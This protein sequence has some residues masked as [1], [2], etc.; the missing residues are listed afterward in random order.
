M[1]LRIKTTSERLRTNHIDL[2]E[3]TEK[4]SQENEKL[5]SNM[6]KLLR[7]SSLPCANNT[8]V[9]DDEPK[10]DPEKT[11]MLSEMDGLRAEVVALRK[12]LLAGEVDIKTLKAKAQLSQPNNDERLVNL[13][14]RLD[15]ETR[16]RLECAELLQGSQA[17][18]LHLQA[19]NASLREELA[20]TLLKVQYN[21]RG[22]MRRYAA[23]S[24]LCCS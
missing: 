1:Q 14:A 5:K 24:V 6:D 19:A 10:D 21:N 12:K 7:S 3:Y 22:L 18:T 8:Y 20:V 2:L 17:E 11:R 9:D 23:D 4:L 15:E 16:I 13:R